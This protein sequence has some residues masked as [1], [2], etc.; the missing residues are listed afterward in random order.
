L[1]YWIH[2][3]TTILILLRES[4]IYLDECE[5][6]VRNIITNKHEAEW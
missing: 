3:R 1:H 5:C 4:G 6:R 2:F